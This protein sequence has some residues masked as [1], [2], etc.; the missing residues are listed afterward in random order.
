MF[1]YE[2]AP[3]PALQPEVVMPAV[4]EPV[5]AGAAPVESPD[6]SGPLVK[7]AEEDPGVQRRARQAA[8][9]IMENESLMP[10]LDSSTAQVLLEWGLDCVRKVA[11]SSAGL[12]DDEAEE[13]MAPRLKATRQMM[14]AVNHWIGHAGEASEQ[15]D[16]QAVEK[17]AE[18]LSV[19][20][21]ER[22]GGLDADRLQE[23][24]QEIRDLRQHPEQWVASLRRSLESR[25]AGQ[26]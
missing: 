15:A 20:D 6:P 17:I 26:E 13:A 10:D 24:L 21:G 4:P 18:N 12:T 22:F 7:P 19:I 2:A 23:I 14:R 8:E 3:E 16:A 25:A 1:G 11:A 5:D 9:A